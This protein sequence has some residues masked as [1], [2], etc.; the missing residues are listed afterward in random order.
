MFLSIL[1]IVLERN[2]EN[3]KLLNQN[4]NEPEMWQTF[5]LAALE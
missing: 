4:T 2:T 1:N 3:W 5:G